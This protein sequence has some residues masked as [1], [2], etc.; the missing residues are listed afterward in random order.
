MSDKNAVTILSADEPDPRIDVEPGTSTLAL[1]EWYWV[2]EIVR[3][4]GEWSDDGVPR[5]K[6]DEVEWLG[7]VMH[8]GTNYIELHSPHRKDGHSTIRV[9]M[10]NYWTKLRNEPDADAVIARN[11]RQY[12]GEAN[13]LMQ[14]VKDIARRLGLTQTRLSGPQDVQEGHGTALATLSGQDDIGTYKNALVEAKE[15]TLPELYKQIETAHKHLATWM[16]APTM[17]MRALMEPLKDKIE[18]IDGRIFNVT[19]YAGLTEDVAMC[20]DGDPAPMGEKLRIMQRRLYMDEE[21]LL[22]YEAGGMEFNNIGEYDEWLSRP[23]NRD[24]I[25]PFPRC[26]VAMRVRRNDKERENFGNIKLAFE[27][28]EKQNADKFTFLYIRNGDRVYRMNCD[29]DFDEMIF[30]DPQ[31]FQPNELMMVNRSFGRIEKMVPLSRFEFWKAEYAEKKKLQKAWNAKNKDDEFHN[32]HGWHDVNY[33]IDGHERFRE[34]DW[35][36][37]DQSSVYYDDTVKNVADS[38]RKYN[39]IA[40]IV[41]GLF[42]RSDVLH[43]HPPVQTWTPGGFAASIELIYDSTNVLYASEKPDFEA[44]RRRL[45]ASLQ[46]GSMVVGQDDFW[47][48][49]EAEKECARLRNDYRNRSDWRPTRFRPYGDPGPG[50]VTP[51]Y[52]FQ[53]KARKAS[54]H[55]HKERQGW[56]PPR[57]KEDFVVK[58]LTVP[59][60]ELLNVS[61][62]TPGDYKQFFRDPRTRAEYLQWAPLLLAAEDYHAELRQKIMRRVRA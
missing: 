31:E 28:I 17:P 7:C 13:R 5:K 58:T 44:Y 19:L 10:D 33:Y 43:P 3:W 30:P 21:C 54:F 29:L 2:K 57:G 12:Q 49:R 39:R 38:I 52:N 32:P 47:T 18:E 61:A 59:A 6:G 46:D 15:T 24:R 27:N 26:I 36:P 40:I 1:G 8:I 20:A 9:H 62:Y 34:S 16:T 22:N 11:V 14:E 41:Q 56:P 50:L 60:D 23:E 48:R 37:F 25:L 53:P 51:I 45:N 55:W 35:E 4:D 42:D